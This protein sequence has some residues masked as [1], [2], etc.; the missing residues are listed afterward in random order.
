MLSK[1]CYSQ[2]YDSRAERRNVDDD[3]Y[4]GILGTLVCMG[5]MCRD[6]YIL[7]LAIVNTK[8]WLC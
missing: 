5:S 6:M 4:V 7:L 3:G 2:G 8:L 1:Q